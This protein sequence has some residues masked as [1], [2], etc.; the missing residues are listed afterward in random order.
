MDKGHPN[1]AIAGRSA[2]DLK[3]ESVVSQSQDEGVVD[4]SKA[5]GLD[6]DL[7]TRV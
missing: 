6:W 1:H 7:S 3:A 5:S 4:A 2:P